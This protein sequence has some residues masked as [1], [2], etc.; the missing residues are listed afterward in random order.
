MSVYHDPN[1]PIKEILGQTF[2]V[3]LKSNP[4]TGYTWKEEH[5]ST[6][7]ELLKPKEFISRSSEVGG[8][9]EEIFEFQTRQLGDTHIKMEYQREWETTPRK[10]KLF[11]VHITQ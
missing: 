9:G 3:S 7:I 10:N 4:S 6:M 11:T 5:D 8:G 1:V 2:T